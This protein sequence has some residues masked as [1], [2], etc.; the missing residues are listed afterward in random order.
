METNISMKENNFRWQLNSF[1]A[2]MT[3]VSLEELSLRV[4]IL[5]HFDFFLFYWNNRKKYALFSSVLCGL[6][7]VWGFSL[8]KG[9]VLTASVLYVRIG[10]VTCE[11]KPEVHAGSGLQMFVDGS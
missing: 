5:L 9:G 7:T 6:W 11:L 8:V 1:A 3:S 2:E 4:K 10:L